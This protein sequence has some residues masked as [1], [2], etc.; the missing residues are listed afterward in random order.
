MYCT[1]IKGYGLYSLGEYPYAVRTADK[2]D[3]LT[4]E[5]FKI[6][7]PVISREIYELEINANYFLD[8]IN[9]EDATVGIYLFEKIGNHPKVKCGD[10]VDFFGSQEKY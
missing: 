3:Q 4:V 6:T 1:R 10:W 8:Y 9:L 7:D 2:T 5:V